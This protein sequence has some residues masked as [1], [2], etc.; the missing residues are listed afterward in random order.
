MTLH[1]RD[2]NWFLAQVKPNC[3]HIAQRNLERQGYQTFLPLEDVTK[4]R[5]GKFVTAKRALFPGYI[6][7][8]FDAAHGLWRSVNGTHGIT[9]LVSFGSAPAAVPQDLVSSLMER[10]S[11]DG[12]LLPPKR[13]QPGDSVLLTWGA[14]ANFVAEVE[15][16]D[17]DRRVWVLMDIM[18]GLTRVQVSA[19]QLRSA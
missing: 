13:L 16:I 12:T 10:C 11:D 3:S 18:G 6:F 14:F 9:S 19:D 2:T 17:P 4:Q 15:V 5:M 1:D 7:V 8:A